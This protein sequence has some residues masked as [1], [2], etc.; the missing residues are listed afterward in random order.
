MFLA[1]EEFKEHSPQFVYT[2]FLHGTAS[3]LLLCT[4]FISE[5]LTQ[6]DTRQGN[7]GQNHSL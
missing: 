2:I 3:W 1:L 4:F 6:N 5:F 7:C